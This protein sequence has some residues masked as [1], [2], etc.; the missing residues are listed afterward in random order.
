M[1]YV[2][3]HRLQEYADKD[4]TAIV[5]ALWGFIL[6]LIFGVFGFGTW[7]LRLVFE[8]SRMA[9]ESKRSRFLLSP[10]L[11]SYLCTFVTFIPFKVFKHFNYIFR[12]SFKKI[13]AA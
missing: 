12:V 8:F 6:D 1:N 7:Y 9:G 10:R 2:V 13:K 5:A 11:C 3:Q 4:D